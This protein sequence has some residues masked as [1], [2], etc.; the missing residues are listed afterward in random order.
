MFYCP[1]CGYRTLHE[2]PP[3]TYLICPI[4][5]WEDTGETWDLR[6]A[7]LNFVSF[8]ACNPQWLE[9][10]RCPTER[11]ER[12]PNWQLLDEQIKATGA[13]V[14]AQIIAAFKSVKREDG[15]SPHEAHEIFLIE[16][17]AYNFSINSSEAK[18][19]LVSAR[20]IDTD[21][22]WQE[23]SQERLKKFVDI[24]GIYYYYLDPKG[25]RYYLP[26]YMVWSLQQYMENNFYY[27][28]DVIYKFLHQEQHKVLDRVQ[29]SFHKLSMSEYL[30]LITAEQLASICDF[31]QFSTN[32]CS[33]YRQEKVQKAIKRHWNHICQGHCQ[34]EGDARYTEI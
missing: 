26:A 32:Y 12:D 21:V 4:C 1:C 24:I 34:V 29:G 28:H 16:D 3:G 18:A 2:R 11:D 19:I 5:F 22:C 27:F 9:Q 23:I 31:L 30:S 7:Q 14:I 25:W 33:H 6:Q 15:I 8:G 10:V 17:Y 13:R 20:A